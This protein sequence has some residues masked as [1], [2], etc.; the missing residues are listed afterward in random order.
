MWWPIVQPIVWAHK[1]GLL[2]LE[3]EICGD[4]ARQAYAIS[5]TQCPSQWQRMY[6][7]CSARG[8]SG[9]QL[10]YHRGLCL[11]PWKASVLLKS[12]ISVAVTSALYTEKYT[13]TLPALLNDAFIISNKAFFFPLRSLSVSYG[14]T[15]FLRQLVFFSLS[16]VAQVTPTKTTKKGSAAPDATK[17][18]VNR[19]LW[20][21][22][23]HIKH[24]DSLA[25]HIKDVVSLIII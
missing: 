12:C 13:V 23:T 5:G 17:E 10:A 24:V 7:I 15:L 6:C 22:S 8:L 3:V 21:I 11:H 16:L 25:T 1:G 14:W 9:P 18:Q 20:C 2:E 19:V 4:R